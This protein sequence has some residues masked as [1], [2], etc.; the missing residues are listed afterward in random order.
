MEKE[1]IERRERHLAFMM[2]MN[3]DKRKLNKNSN[4]YR[5]VMELPPK[6]K[7]DVVTASEKQQ[8]QQLKFGIV[9][10]IASMFREVVAI[11]YRY[12]HNRDAG[13][14]NLF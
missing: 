14:G 5:K 8:A 7:R 2:S 4:L 11:S 10:Q 9:V 13:Y 3:G 6:K 12:Y 1:E